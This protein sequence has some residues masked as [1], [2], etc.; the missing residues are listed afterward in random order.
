MIPSTALL[1]LLCAA[2]SGPAHLGVSDF[3]ASGELG[4]L[5]GALSGLVANELQRMGAFKVTSSRQVSDLLS[6]ERSKQLMGCATDECATAAAIDLGFDFLVTGTLTRYAG[7]PGR[8]GAL[9]LELLLLAAKTSSREGSEVVTGADEAELMANVSPAVARLV[10]KLLKEKSGG[11]VVLSSEAGSVLKVDDVAVGTTPLGGMLQVPGGPHY[12]R[13]EKEGFVAWQKEIRISPDKVTEESVRLVPSPDF[14][15]AYESK[16]VK[17]RAGAWIA[18]AVAVGAFAA[19]IAFE[20]RSA[21]LYGAKDK[22]GTFLALR[23]KVANGDE[24]A[25]EALNQQRAQISSNQTLTGVFA[26][27]AV[28]G[29]A[30]ATV[31]WLLGEDPNRYSA[32]RELKVGAAA[33]PGGGIAVLSG[34]W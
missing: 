1:T 31:L 15:A 34:G 27:I 18:S 8:R 9:T 3:R 33:G 20:S 28:A 6:H 19:A 13:L 24:G 29:A 16:Q 11:L 4:P 32:Y 10:A 25:R 21:S 12:L 14:I 26:G 23:E 5:G 17:L 30:G 22:D 2:A 7:V